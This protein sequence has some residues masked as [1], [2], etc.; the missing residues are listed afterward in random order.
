MPK[1]EP[2][3]SEIKLDKKAWVEADTLT[4]MGVDPGMASTGVVILTK[5]EGEKPICQ[6]V[7][8]IRTKKAEK[9]DRRG[10]RVT[11]D[12][13]RRMR[14]IWNG[15]ADVHQ[16]HRPQALAFEVYT[17]YRAQGGTAWKAARIEGAVQMFGLERQMLVLPFL[18]QDLKRN[19]CGKLG[20]SKQ[21]VQDAMALKVESLE[22]MMLRLPKT[23]REHVADA[24]GHAYL[25]FEEIYRM[26]S[27]MG[28]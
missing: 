7:E 1:R 17:P 22:A 15:L 27:M 24:A 18:P 5:A 4:V 6:H 11:A 8:V 3:Q 25:A 28:F 2:M 16:A 10:L 21:E 19:F 20:A 14:E 9:K 23:I 13:S 26:R 12:D